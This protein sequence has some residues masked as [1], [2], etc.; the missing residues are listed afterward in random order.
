MEETGVGARLIG[1]QRIW[2]M[3]LE[4]TDRELVEACQRGEREG[5]RA[6]F[7]RHKDRVYSIALRYSGDESTAMDIAQETFLKLFSCIRGFRGESSFES[8]L[9]RLVVNSCLERK[10]KEQRLIS[11]VGQLHCGLD[12][13]GDKCRTAE[14]AEVQRREGV[15]RGRAPPQHRL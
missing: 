4:E 11:L 13:P 8:W 10:R 14:T 3:V 15:V 6:L 1:E 12:E 5:F 9:Y 2:R 7:E